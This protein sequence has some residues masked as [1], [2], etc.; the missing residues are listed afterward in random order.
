MSGQRHLAHQESAEGDQAS[1]T[2][3]MS[4]VYFKGQ[5]Y[6]VGRRGGERLSNEWVREKKRERG[7]ERMSERDRQRKKERE[8]N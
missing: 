1:R 7:R 2:H 6:F 8:R 4:T 5:Y 3:A